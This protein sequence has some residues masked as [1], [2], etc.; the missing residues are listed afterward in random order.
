MPFANL[1]QIG[2][3]ILV[4]TLRRMT[5]MLVRGKPPLPGPIFSYSRTVYST[6]FRTQRLQPCGD[7]SRPLLQHP[8]D[9]RWP[10][11]FS[12]GKPPQNI[13]QTSF[14]VRLFLFIGRPRF[15]VHPLH[16][17]GYFL[18]LP[19]SLCF[20][21]SILLFSH[22][23]PFRQE[24]YIPKNFRGRTGKSIVNVQVLALGAPRCTWLLRL[25]PN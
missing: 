17:S 23:Y 13:W 4:F 25:N 3:V 10:L 15:A 11:L 6:S 1:G 22:G 2:I 16:G 12:N 5:L 8:T 21:I 20:P 14:R 18:P 7:L 19:I 24:T 9:I